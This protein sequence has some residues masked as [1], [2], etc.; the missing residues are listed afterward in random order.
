MSQFC[1]MPYH[2]MAITPFVIAVGVVLFKL[3][4]KTSE[5]SIGFRLPSNQKSKAKIAAS[6]TKKVTN[7]FITPPGITLDTELYIGQ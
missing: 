6:K 7:F 1:E 4:K 2:Y 5:Y 3:P